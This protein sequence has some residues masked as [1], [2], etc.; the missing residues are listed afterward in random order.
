MQHRRPPLLPIFLFKDGQQVARFS[1][2]LPDPRFNKAEE[3]LDQA[4]Q[5]VNLLYKISEENELPQSCDMIEIHWGA[6][7]FS[8]NMNFSVERAEIA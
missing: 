8:R 2:D 7:H 3:C 6:G 5:Y 4:I 1:M